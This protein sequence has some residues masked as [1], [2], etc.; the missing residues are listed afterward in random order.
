MV[1]DDEEYQ[2]ETRSIRAKRIMEGI[3]ELEELGELTASLD[4]DEE[5]GDPR[6]KGKKK[7]ITGVDKDMLNMR[8]K[9]LQTLRDALNLDAKKEELEEADALNLFFIPV[10]K[11]EFERLKT[12]EVN[13]GDSDGSQALAEEAAGSLPNIQDV[14][15]RL[16]G[17]MASNTADVPYITNTD[18]SIEEIE[19]V[20]KIIASASGKV[21]SS[22]VSFSRETLVHACGGLWKRQNE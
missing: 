19:Y 12:V 17:S 22:A 4:A 18:G 21:H 10:T 15:K 13:E 3:K 8:F 14:E 1:L 7:K 16:Q 11:D 20:K 5:S 9:A 2:Q 6:E